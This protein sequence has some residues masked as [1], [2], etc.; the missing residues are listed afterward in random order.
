MLM[1]AGL[2]P[3]L[4]LTFACCIQNA[5]PPTYPKARDLVKYK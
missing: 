1:T 5:Y 4:F 3:V 2:Q